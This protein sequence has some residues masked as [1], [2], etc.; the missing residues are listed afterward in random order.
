MYGLMHMTETTIRLLQPGDEAALEAFLLPRMASSM[1]LISNLRA[2][3][4]VYHGELY[5]AVYAAAFEDGQIVGVVAHTWTE[6]LLL[7]APVQIAALVWTAVKATNRAI[8]GVVGP[9]DQV[10]AV[11]A[12][13]DAPADNASMDE[14]ENLYRL[15][16]VA[17]VEPA[18]LRLGEVRGRRIEAG[19]VELLTRWRIAYSIE[20]L[21]DEETPALHERCRASVARALTTGQSWVL[22]AAGTPV[23]CSSFN[24][25]ID[26]AVQVGGVW[27]PPAWRGRG[28]GRA[29]VAASLLDA[30]AEGVTSAILF[31]GKSNLPAQKA[32]LALGFHHIGDYRLTLFRSPLTLGGDL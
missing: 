29:V 32:Y 2:A 22:E 13:L 16:L 5:Q 17:L 10:C 6:N 30:R 24:A 21:G 23:A 25:A 11:N 20:A 9:D 1:F 7:Q 14:A 26:E 8:R 28:Y 15:L 19:D 31:T 4:L 27:T 18:A 3:G 12:L